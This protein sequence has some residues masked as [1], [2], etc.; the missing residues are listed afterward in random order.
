MKYTKQQRRN[1]HKAF[2]AAQPYLEEQR[3]ICWA[4]GEAYTSGKIDPEQIKLARGLIMHRIHPYFT[5][6][7]WLVRSAGIQEMELTPEAKAAYRKRW[8]VSLVR[9]FSK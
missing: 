2:K 1:L 5:V 8:L 4:L 9:E 3:F 7:D 6:S